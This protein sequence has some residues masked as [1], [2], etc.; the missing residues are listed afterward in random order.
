MTVINVSELR[1]AIHSTVLS[2]LLLKNKASV[3][4]LLYCKRVAPKD[5]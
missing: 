3:N 4:T 5:F 1:K 2:K